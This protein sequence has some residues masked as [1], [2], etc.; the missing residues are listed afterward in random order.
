MFKL[1]EATFKFKTESINK[2]DLRPYEPFKHC[3]SSYFGPYYQALKHTSHD[4][5][6]TLHM[7]EPVKTES[8]AREVASFEDRSKDDEQQG[9]R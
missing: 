8:I 4:R 7:R 2:D 5:S 9:L 6:G 3:S 1:P